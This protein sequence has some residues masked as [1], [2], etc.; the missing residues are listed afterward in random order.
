MFEMKPKLREGEAVL[1]EY[2]ATV[3]QVRGGISSGGS[4]IRLFLTDQRLILKAGIGPQRTLPIY[5]IRDIREEKIGL[6]NMARLE[7]SDGHLEWFTVQN[8]SQFLQALESVRAQAPVIPDFGP[9]A[10]F[11]PG[12]QTTRNRVFIIVLIIVGCVLMCIC[13][14]AVLLGAFFFFMQA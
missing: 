12:S 13:L 2:G 1:G 4:N 11:S 6:W 9:E 10:S 3:Y 7:F 8:Q 5:A 14:L